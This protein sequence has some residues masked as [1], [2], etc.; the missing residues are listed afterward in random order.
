MVTE[1]VEHLTLSFYVSVFSSVVVVVVIYVLF[2]QKCFVWFVQQQKS[3]L[4]MFLSWH[5][6]QSKNWCWNFQSS[7][8]ALAVC[9]QLEVFVHH[10]LMTWVVVCCTRWTA[11]IA[12]LVWQ[13]HMHHPQYA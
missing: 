5:A 11:D 1:L 13:I 9:H 8:Q 7:F 2:T 12:T 6:T 10:W 3:M 4:L